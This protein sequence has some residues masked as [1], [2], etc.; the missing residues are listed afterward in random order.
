MNPLNLQITFL[1]GET[2]TVSAIAPDLV[3]FESHFDMS[4]AALADK[5]RLTHMFFLAWHV[6]KRT[7]KTEMPFEEWVETISMVNEAPVKK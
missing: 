6:L 4:V 5:V 2:V 3:A 1:D 7:K